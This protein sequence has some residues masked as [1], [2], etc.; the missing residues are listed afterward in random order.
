MALL[1][2]RKG[3]VAFLI[4]GLVFFLVATIVMLVVVAARHGLLGLHH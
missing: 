3:L 2:Q 4:A 1:P